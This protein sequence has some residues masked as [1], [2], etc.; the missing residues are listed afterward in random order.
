MIVLGTLAL[1]AG[2]GQAQEMAGRAH[3]EAIDRLGWLEGEWRGAAWMQ[4]GPQ[5]QNADQLERVYRAAGGT[6]LVI[7]GLG[8]V[9]GT[10][11]VVHDAFAVLYWNEQAKRYEFRSFLANGRTL[12]T[13]AEVGDRR[14]VWGFQSPEAGRIRYTITVTP[15]GDW[16]EVGERSTD[17]GATWAQFFEMT[18]KRSAGA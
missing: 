13:T 5:R 1:A 11:Q 4:M 10:Q 2:A 6:V 8:K 16:R 3:R 17:N 12:E 7:H 15:A 9:A 14:L 18:L